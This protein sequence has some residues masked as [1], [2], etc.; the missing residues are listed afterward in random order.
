MSRKTL[1][2]KLGFFSSSFSHSA[3]DWSFMCKNFFTLLS[4]QPRY[5][6]THLPLSFIGKVLNEL[7]HFFQ[8]LYTVILFFSFAF[9]Y[10]SYISQQVLNVSFQSR[11]NTT[12]MSPLRNKPVHRT[13]ILFSCQV[14]GRQGWLRSLGLFPYQEREKFTHFTCLLWR[15]PWD[16]RRYSAQCLL[17]DGKQSGHL[18]LYTVTGTRKLP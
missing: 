10:L 9:L 6:R 14:K 12:V 3:F 2:S 13:K 17:M 1:S 16:Y 15:V 18:V 8:F 5:R 7:P 11:L 4:I